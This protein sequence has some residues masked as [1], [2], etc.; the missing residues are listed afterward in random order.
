MDRRVET[1]FAKPRRFR[2]P[3]L[4]L[5]WRPALGVAAV[6]LIAVVVA[7]A[8]TGGSDNGGGG[9]AVTAAQEQLRAPAGAAAVTPGGATAAPVRHVERSAEL[10]IAAPA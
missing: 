4:R 7:I 8:V 5:T 9:G 10:T 1:R 3:A 2:L 6:A